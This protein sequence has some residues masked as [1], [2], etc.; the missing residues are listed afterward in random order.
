MMDLP[1]REA[2]DLADGV[3]DPTLADRPLS[4]DLDA[5]ATLLDQ[6]ADF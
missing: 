3:L 4:A 2:F 5:A 1:I 6:F